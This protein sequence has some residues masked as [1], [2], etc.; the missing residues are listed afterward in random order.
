VPSAIVY[1]KYFEG[2]HKALYNRNK[3]HDRYPAVVLPKP[4][5]EGKMLTTGI[6]LT[7]FLGVFV[8]VSGLVLTL[9]LALCLI[10]MRDAIADIRDSVKPL[11]QIDEEVRR[12][13]LGGKE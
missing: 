3:G 13:E 6:F 7:V 2:R 12:M 11:K 1:T 4:G 5:G 8:G 10:P 9:V